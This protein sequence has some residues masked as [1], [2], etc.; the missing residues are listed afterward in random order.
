MKKVVFLLT[1]LLLTSTIF[2]QSGLDVSA[3]IRARQQMNNKDF[4]SDLATNNFS[5]LRTR[6][7]LKFSPVENISGLVQLQDSRVYGTEPS[8]LA[9]ID[10]I[11]L[12]QA[13]VQVN[14][15]FNLPLNLKLG[16]MELSFGPQRLVGAVGWHNVGRSFDGGV[17]QLKTKKVDIDFFSAQTNESFEAGDTNDFSVV[18]AYG[19]LKLVKNYKIQPF[20]IGELQ[21]G[22]DFS[23][24]TLGV[25]INGNVGNLSHEIEGAYQLGSITEDVDIAAYM[26]AL[27]VKYAFNTPIK[28]SVGL[29]VDYLS[30]NDGTDDKYNV[31]N[32]LYAT[33]HKYYGFMDYFLNIP[34]HTYGLGLMDLHAKINVTPLAKFKMELAFHIFN[35]IEEYNY[36]TS[37]SPTLKT[38]NSFGSEID[39]TLIYAYDSAVKFQGGLSLFSP[40]DIF[41][42]TRGEDSST[43]GYLMAV[44]NL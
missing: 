10:N 24:Y 30:G 43:W 41:K 12:H 14:K 1:I 38:S 28:P 25:Y 36:T 9:S 11:D 44:V 42:Q 7:N 34:A 5:E 23:R 35:S 8:T 37:D 18:G 33:N 2:A 32:T 40:G 4:N 17:L 3:Q 20:V 19:N 21:T 6:L 15:L 31:F 26:F 39:L 16:R 27:N 29:G 22:T 13:F